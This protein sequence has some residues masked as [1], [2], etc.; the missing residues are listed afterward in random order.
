MANSSIV[1]TMKNKVIREMCKN[2]RLFNAINSSTIINFED[3][4]D[5]IGK[6]IFRYNQNPNTIEGAISFITVQVHIAD[7]PGKNKVWTRSTLEIWV[8]SHERCMKVD[9]IE[10]DRTD[11]IS[12]IIDEMFNNQDRYGYGRLQLVSNTEGVFCKDWLYRK[13]IFETKDFNDSMCG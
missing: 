4:F 7:T 3:S 10:D 12:R 13:M 9:K 2:E 1:T 5:L 11:Y 6:H 8:Y